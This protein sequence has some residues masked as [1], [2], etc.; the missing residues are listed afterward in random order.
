[1]GAPVAQARD[2]DHLVTMYSTMKPKKAGVLFNEH[3]VP[4]EEHFNLNYPAF[5]DDFLWLTQKIAK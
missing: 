5:L 2:I 1:V 3:G 4:V